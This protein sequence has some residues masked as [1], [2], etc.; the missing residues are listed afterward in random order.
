MSDTLERQQDK[1]R[2]P[3]T[4]WRLTSAN[5]ECG[6]AVSRRCIHPAQPVGRPMGRM[7]SSTSRRW[8]RAI[9]GNGCISTGRSPKV[10]S[11]FFIARRSG[12]G[13]TIT[14]G[15]TSFGLTRRQGCR[16]LGR[17]AGRSGDVSP[18]QRHVLKHPSTV[19][20]DHDNDQGNRVSLAHR[21]RCRSPEA[22]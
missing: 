4:T 17:A 9:P 1:R 7:R 3:F 21:W 18:R 6:R 15:S 22:G 20:E 19:K 12:P 8:R 11:W 5:R 2:W 16:A 13:M 14:R 10:T